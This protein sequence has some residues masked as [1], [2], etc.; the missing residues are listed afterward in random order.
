MYFRVIDGTGY[1]LILGGLFIGARFN[2]WCDA[3]AGWEPLS[4][5]FGEIRALVDE[6]IVAGS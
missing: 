1:E 6:A 4:A 2:W 3:P 5:L